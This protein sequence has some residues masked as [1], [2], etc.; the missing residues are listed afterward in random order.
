[1]KDRLIFFTTDTG[2][3]LPALNA[4]LQAAAQPAVREIADI[5]I[6]LVGI[7]DEL[8]R[9]LEAEFSPKGLIFF[10]LDPAEFELAD[11]S[12]I[13]DTHVRPSA[14]A[15]L[16]AARHIPENYEH[17]VYLDGDIQ[18][19]GDL[20][21][22]VEHDVAPGK[23]LA[24]T[25]PHFICSSPRGETGRKIRNYARALGLKDPEIYF[26]SGVMAFRRETW[27]KI[28]PEALAFIAENTSLC[29]LFDQSALNAILNGRRELL[30]TSFNYAPFIARLGMNDLAPA[31]VHFVGPH[32]PWH[33][34]YD[35]MPGNWRK[36]YDDLVA[37]HPLLEDF[38][39]KGP[40]SPAPPENGGWLKR[41]VG[42]HLQK[43]RLKRYLRSHQFDVGPPAGRLRAEY[44]RVEN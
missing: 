19:V 23:I 43:R 7:D 34:H 4:A 8:F 5:A 25:E 31:I 24:A 30:H 29:W 22:L 27:I 16:I 6:F 15:R 39:N 32:K 18:I 41:S 3:L 33:T 20:C 40:D 13:R 1:M 21:P 36:S 17:I 37:R 2:F 11:Y 12:V 28:A 10:R 38:W 44:P 26:N 9:R 14:L 35:Y 42:R